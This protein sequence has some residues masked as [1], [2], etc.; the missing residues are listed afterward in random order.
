MHVEFW[1]TGLAEY[2]ASWNAQ[3]VK[4]TER[5]L[6]DKYQIGIMDP[7]N[8]QVNINFPTTEGA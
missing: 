2:R 7:D 6:P 5:M 4:F 8:I 3:G 1:A